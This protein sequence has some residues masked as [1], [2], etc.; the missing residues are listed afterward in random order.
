MMTIRIAIRHRA[1]RYSL[2]YWLLGFWVFEG[3][4]WLMYG[5]A[6]GAYA[7]LRLVLPAILKFIGVVCAV[8]FVAF[9][10]AWSLLHGRRVNRQSTGERAW[11]RTR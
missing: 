3:M 10:G 11:T 7:L 4:F 8:V 1:F 9:L 6:I 5:T 2:A